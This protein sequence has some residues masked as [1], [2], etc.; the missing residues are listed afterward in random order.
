MPNSKES[1]LTNAITSDHIHSNNSPLSLSLTSPGLKFHEDVTFGAIARA[2]ALPN[3]REGGWLKLAN[4]KLI[5]ENY[6]DYYSLLWEIGSDILEKRHLENGLNETLEL[7]LFY[8][9]KSWLISKG[10]KISNVE[11]RVNSSNIYLQSTEFIDSNEILLSMPMSLIMCQQTARNVVIYK[12]GR[13]L[14][15]ELQK[16]FDKDEFWGLTIFLLHEY[17]KE[18]NGEGSKWGPFIR[19]LKMRVLT[20]Q[21]LQVFN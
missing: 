13:Y 14:G 21:N 15:E 1:Y 11:P 2:G 5:K 20:T 6:L 8:S 3:N 7:E 17:Y 16:T 12:R 10:G 19:S 4:D 18:I 9:L